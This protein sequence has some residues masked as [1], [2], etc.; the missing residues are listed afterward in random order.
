MIFYGVWLLFKKKY[1][2]GMPHLATFILLFSLYN[3]LCNSCSIAYIHPVYGAGI[4]TS[5]SLDYE[6]SAI[7][8][9]PV[10][11][12]FF[13]LWATSHIFLQR[14]ATLFLL[15]CTI[16]HFY[17]VAFQRRN[18]PFLTLICLLHAKFLI[19]LNQKA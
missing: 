5:Q 19:L 11:S 12:N 2:F 8:T 9:R 3:W 14:R 13:N 18:V 10:V 7:T 4:Q 16:F 15:T 17:L 1:F 6:S